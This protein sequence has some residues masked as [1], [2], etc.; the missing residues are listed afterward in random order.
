M[1]PFLRMCVSG[2][3]HTACLSHSCTASRLCLGLTCSLIPLT[4][5]LKVPH[6]M[7]VAQEPPASQD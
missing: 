7:Q 2:V 6:V 3:P 1:F 4:G 5:H